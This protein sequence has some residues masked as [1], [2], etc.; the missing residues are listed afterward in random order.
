MDERLESEQIPLACPISG[1]K[2]ISN[3]SE[4]AYHCTSFRP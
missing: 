3:D 1:T 4:R 2:L